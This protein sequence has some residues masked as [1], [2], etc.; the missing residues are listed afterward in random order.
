MVLRVAGNEIPVVETFKYLGVIFDKKLTY[1]NHIEYL[2]AKC[3]KRLNLQRLLT[4]TSWGASQK[5]LL[6]L[7]RASIRSVIDYGLQ[8]YFFAAKCHTAKVEK[9]NNQALRLCCGAMRSTP[10]CVLEVDC[11]EMPLHI[12][13]KYLCLLYR[14]RL[15]S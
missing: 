14:C 7:C 3:S 11:N 4:S 12:R 15:L 10:I 13:H 2:I 5:S 6:M 9:V 8:A 1:K